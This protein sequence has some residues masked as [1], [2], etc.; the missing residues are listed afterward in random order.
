M[1]KL[2]TLKDLKCWGDSPEGYL[3]AKDAIKQEAIKWVKEDLNVIK[4]NPLLNVE[5]RVANQF[6]SRWMKRF[7]ITSEDLK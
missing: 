7:N 1:T 6:V 3:L 2:K 4:N 5:E